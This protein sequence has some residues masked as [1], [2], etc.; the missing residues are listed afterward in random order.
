MVLER[1]VNLRCFSTIL[2]CLPQLHSQVLGGSHTA[3]RSSVEK[4]DKGITSYPE[5]LSQPV[6]IEAG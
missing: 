5:K 4:L 6:Q 3:A 2:Q 1:N